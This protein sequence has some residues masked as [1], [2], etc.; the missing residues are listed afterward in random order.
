MRKIVSVLLG[1]LLSIAAYA[2]M[3]TPEPIV[4]TQADGTTVTLKLVGDEF[5]SYYTTLDGTPVRLNNKGMWVKDES[6]TVMPEK[7]KKARRIAQQTMLSSNYPLTGSPKSLVILV[8]FKDLAFQ[9]KLEDF[10][11]LLTESGYSTN[12]G[13]GSARD[14]FIACSDSIFS[15]QFD[16]YGPVTLGREMAYYGADEGGDHSPHADLM[17]VEACNL[18]D[19]LGIDLTQY[20]TDNDGR[21][22]NVFVYYAGHNQAE[23]ASTNTIWPHRS[24]VGG[25]NRVQGLLIHDY[26]CTSELRGSSGKSMCGIGT[27]CHEFGH[28]LGLPDYYDTES[29]STYTV[30]SW[31]IMCSGSYNG[32]GKT[33]PSYTAGERFQLSWLKPVQ[34]KDAGTYTLEPL[35]TTNTAY[36]IAKTEHNLSFSSANPNEY[37]LLENRQ[38]VG[39]DRHSTSLPGTGMLIWHVEYNASIWGANTPNNSTPQRYHIE[40]AGGKR[41]YSADSDPYPG[42]KKVTTFTPMLHN[43]DIVEQPLTDIAESGQNITFTFKSNGFMFLPTELPVI[44]STYNPD[45][46]QAYTPGSKVRIVGEGLIPNATVSIAVSTNGFSISNDSTNW[47]SSLSATVGADS[48][49]EKDIYVRYRPGKQ[50]CDIQRGTITVRQDKSVGTLTIRGTSPRPVLIEAPDITSVL[51]VTPTSFLLKWAPQQ[52]AEEYYVTLYHLEEGRES[53]MESFEGFDDEMTVAESGWWTSFYRTTTKAKEEGAVSMWFKEN[54]E[55]LLSPIYP[56]P[57]VELSM[58]LNAPATTET[59]VGLLYLV[60]YSETGGIDTLDIIHITKNTKKQ[61]YS[62][63]FTEEQGYR[64]FELSYTALG[65]EGLCLDAFTTTFNKKTIY[66]YQGREKTIIPQ[67]LDDQERYTQFYAYDLTPNTTYYLRMQ[68]SE[69]KGCEEHLSELSQISYVITPEGE[70]ADSKHLTLAYD[71]INYDPATNVIYLPQ[72]LSNGSLNIYNPDGELIKSIP[73]SMHHNIIPINKEEFAHGALYLLKYLPEDKMA[74][75][76]P[77]I[78]VIFR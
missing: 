10:Q 45:T 76:S 5:H 28:V 57:V 68:C 42:T 30:G 72:A 35:A 38:N 12:N 74:R 31:D 15:P 71:S 23:G 19:G 22:D 27:F 37:W 69:N 58:W 2:V 39:W 59:E 36:L 21:L 9:Y 1:S 29:S 56:L 3:A 65:G 70:T 44:Q 53:T 24:V 43:G 75:K 7:A 40:E 32:S 77:W 73:V 16:C 6:V 61:T 47:T 13:V 8:N 62:K 33:P 18:V 34:L 11:R 51:E 63:T 26:A 60:G 50:V 64:R 25:N 78:K 55:T 49:L 52:D 46:K 48:L 66:T 41:G 20:D 17:I 54:N 14:Y 4:K 67:D